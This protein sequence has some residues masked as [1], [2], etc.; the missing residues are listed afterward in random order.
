M[1]ILTFL[2]RSAFRR[3]R[4]G[5]SG[6]WGAIAAGLFGFRLL[7][8]WAKR[9]EDVVYRE[10]IKPGQAITVTHRSESRRALARAEQGAARRSR[11]AGRRSA[12]AAPA[13]A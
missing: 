11:R 12:S 3:F 1:T 13:D 10:V 4:N 5:S 2:Q 8:K 7:V 6:P 9:N